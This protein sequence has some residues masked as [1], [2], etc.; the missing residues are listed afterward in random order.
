[1]TA[2]GGRQTGADVDA[3]VD[4]LVDRLVA[5]DSNR[6]VTQAVGEVLVEAQ[7]ASVAGIA[8]ELIGLL[9]RQH[10]T[11][12][13]LLWRELSAIFFFGAEASQDSVLTPH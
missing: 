7:A 3:V 11:D 4:N 8:T 12:A 1:M 6:T 9:V 13:G 10:I 2:K 5:A